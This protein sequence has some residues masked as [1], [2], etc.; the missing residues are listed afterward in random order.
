MNQK[1]EVKLVDMGTNSEEQ[2]NAASFFLVASPNLTKFQVFSEAML[3]QP[4]PLGSSW[5][6]LGTEQK[7]LQHGE[8]EQAIAT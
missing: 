5:K 3:L 8:L 4:A 6:Q 1:L 2:C 7:V